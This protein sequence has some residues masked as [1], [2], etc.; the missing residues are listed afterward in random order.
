MEWILSLF[1]SVFY[2]LRA[3][4]GEILSGR[5][6]CAPLGGTVMENETPYRSEEETSPA[7]VNPTL[8]SD[9]GP[10][11][12]H[13]LG[14]RANTTP[15]AGGS[16]QSMEQK[17][18]T[19]PMVED[20]FENLGPLG[21][22]PPLSPPAG[23]S[24]GPE[25]EKREQAPSIGVN[26]DPSQ[27]SRRL[28]G[29]EQGGNSS[30][31]NQNLSCSHD[32][33]WFKNHAIE[34]DKKAYYKRLEKECPSSMD[35]DDDL[36]RNA[37][38]RDIAGTNNYLRTALLLHFERN[39]PMRCGP[40]FNGGTYDEDFASRINQIMQSEGKS[41]RSLSDLVDLKYALEDAQKRKKILESYFQWKKK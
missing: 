35:G 27:S 14:A 41:T 38:M 6:R 30:K 1:P 24:L 36:K 26:L 8:S 16:S 33:A 37:V 28:D 7:H 18:Q 22:I 23:P 29:G 5:D 4:L 25:H 12:N 19:P 10:S 21:E 31:S 9:S 3:L 39:A 11:V 40:Q 32:E 20:H 15:P 13:H 34:Q 2:I 17:C